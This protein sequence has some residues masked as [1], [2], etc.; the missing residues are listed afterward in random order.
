MPTLE[1]PPSSPLGRTLTYRYEIGEVAWGSRKIQAFIIGGM[2]LEGGSI[3]DERVASAVANR[4]LAEH[5]DLSAAVWAV[6]IWSRAFPL[7]PEWQLIGTGRGRGP[8]PTSESLPGEI[9]DD[10]IRQLEKI[11]SA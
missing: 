4:I 8:L 3:A 9:P 10:V 2:P 6:F 5:T 1:R 7:V 11:F